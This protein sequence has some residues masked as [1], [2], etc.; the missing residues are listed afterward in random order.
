MAKRVGAGLEALSRCQ[1]LGELAVVAAK[2]KK[3]SRVERSRLLAPAALA[4]LPSEC[5]PEAKESSADR[6]AQRCPPGKDKEL[7]TELL[8]DLDPGTYLFV[9][10]V[11]EQLSS[12]GVLDAKAERVLDNLVL[13][14]ALQG[15]TAKGPATGAP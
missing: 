4:K 15:E 10:A 13:S 11:R 14:A 12:L 5:R 2:A 6:L 1:A 8:A 9:L 3:A 7:A